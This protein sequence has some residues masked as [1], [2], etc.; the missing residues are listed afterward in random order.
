MI[1]DRKRGR[2]RLERGALYVHRPAMDQLG[3]PF[4]APIAPG[5]RLLVPAPEQGGMRKFIV[6]R[7]DADGTAHLRPA[8]RTR[9][10]HLL[11]LPL[12]DLARCK[13]VQSPPTPR[14]PDSTTPCANCGHPLKGQRRC[15]H[16]GQH[17]ATEV[18]QH[19]LLA[20]LDDGDFPTR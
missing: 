9:K 2:D 4:T 17:T 16:C 7:V 11:H 8:G 18:R 14:L 15:P 19:D 5:T 6:E 12:A 10:A 3:L 20:D 1:E 13:V